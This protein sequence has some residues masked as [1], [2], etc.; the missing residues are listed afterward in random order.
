MLLAGLVVSNPVDR[1]GN[2]LK[3]VKSG[4]LNLKCE[5]GL[6]IFQRRN[7]DLK[8]HVQTKGAFSASQSRRL[9]RPLRCAYRICPAV[10]GEGTDGSWILAHTQTHGLEIKHWISRDNG[11]SRDNMG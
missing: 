8:N 4:S 10:S 5:I 7:W 2:H 6:R 9:I 11:I 3:Y 1:Q